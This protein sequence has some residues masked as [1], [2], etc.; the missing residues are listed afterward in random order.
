MERYV[1][2]RKIRRKIRGRCR[3]ISKFTV[4]EMNLMCAFGTEN[5]SRLI[6]DIKN[7]LLHLENSEMTEL[8][9]NVLKKL[10]K[11]AEDE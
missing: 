7:V 1:K 9:E 4:E 5:R 10:L 6:T 3:N 8:V 11:S 2:N